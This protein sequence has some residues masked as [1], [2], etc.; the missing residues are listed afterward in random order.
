MTRRGGWTA[1]R[2]GRDDSGRGGTLFALG[3]GPWSLTTCLGL[4][5][6]F[7]RCDFSSTPGTSL[8]SWSFSTDD[9]DGTDV[10]AGVLLK[11][12]EGSGGLSGGLGLSN[13]GGGSVRI[14]IGVAW[15]DDFSGG[16]LISVERLRQTVCILMAASVCS[17]KS[18]LVNG[19]KGSVTIERTGAGVDTA[20]IINNA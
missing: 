13:G 7:K 19:A 12:G 5:G 8:L 3:N 18:L 1:G 14:S 17:I 9:V 20:G 6:G 2:G 10:G 4:T 16:V 15:R 11:V